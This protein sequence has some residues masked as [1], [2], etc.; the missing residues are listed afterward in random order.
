MSARSLTTTTNPL[1]SRLEELQGL[2]AARWVR[3]STRDQ[4]GNQGPHAQTEQIDRAIERYGLIDTR[5]G[6]NPTH[7]GRTIQ[8]APEYAQMIAAAGTTFD[9]LVVGYVSRFARDLETALAARTK[10]HTAGA[11]ILFADDQLLTSDAEHWERWAREALEAEAYSRR[12]GRR[13]SEGHAS[14]W[15]RYDDPPGKACLGM[16]RNPDNDDR[17]EIDPDTIGQVVRLMN[18]YAS[19]TISYRALAESEGLQEARVRE[20]LHQPLFNG[21]ATYKGERKATA[22]RANPPVSDLLWNAVQMKTAQ[23]Q[24][25]T[26]ARNS[27]T[28]HDRI[29]AL[30]GKVFCADC[31]KPWKHNG[32]DGQGQPQRF[33][34]CAGKPS[35]TRRDADVL[36]IPA[37][38]ISQMDLSDAT[39]A[40][41]TK[42]LSTP[43]PATPA[44]DY[45]VLRRQLANRYADGKIT[46]EQFQS[47][48]VPLKPAAITT[49]APATI[50]D[51]QMKA[52]LTNLAETWRTADA[53]TRA[54]LLDAFYQSVEIRD[55]Q[56]VRVTLTPTAGA[57][58]LPLA[59]PE[60]LS[61]EEA[62]QEAQ[63]R[64]AKAADPKEFAMARP[65]GIEP[66][67]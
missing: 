62:L 39:I 23:R 21:W 1:P 44:P 64:Q 28:R 38:M 22:W 26:T 52:K 27:Q 57:L 5:I 13:I 45:A 60:D 15:R 8:K 34:R 66:A 56:V 31:G 18:R 48:L 37:A 65:A 36:A 58:G 11:A 49:P 59:L 30:A 54:A 33:H 10:L 4:Q 47:Q 53:R 50:S 32:T 17:I 19:E 29:N 3:E 51:E 24:T 7:S 2:R 14:R 9:I 46:L 12:L 25:R 55:G 67:T 63:R 41:I 6:W 42:A 16:R 43:E 35:K 40:Q 20:L 61:A